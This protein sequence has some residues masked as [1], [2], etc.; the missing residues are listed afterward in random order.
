MA[1]VHRECGAS[2]RLRQL[3]LRGEEGAAEALAR[4]RAALGPDELLEAILPAGTHVSLP[5]AL[6]LHGLGADALWLVATAPLPPLLRLIG[7]RPPEPLEQILELLAELPSGGRMLAE[8]PHAPAPLLRILNAQGARWE[9]VERPDGS[10][11][12]C[13]TR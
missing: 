13:V 5:D 6:A 1:A 11:L 4:I 8:L 2:G 12:L 9:L 3:D 10:A 7:L